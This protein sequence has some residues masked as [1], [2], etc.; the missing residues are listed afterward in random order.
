V[1]INGPGA[2]A[3]DGDEGGA[4]AAAAAA[5]EGEGDNNNKKKKKK[6]KYKKAN[7]YKKPPS[8]GLNHGTGAGAAGTAA[9]EPP[10]LKYSLND[11]DPAAHATEG[12]RRDTAGDRS[13]AV[14]CFRA[15]ARVVTRENGHDGEGVG[16]AHMNLGVALL[17]V[18]AFGK[19][20]AALDVAAEHAPGLAGLDR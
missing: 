18:G 8:N 19:A 11:P 4:S 5:E 10:K 13:G 15:A 3:I 14:E 16:K 12:I 6:N 17:R 1:T 2:V 7:K 9:A 20:L